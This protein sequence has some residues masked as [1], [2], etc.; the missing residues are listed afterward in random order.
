MQVLPNV[1]KVSVLREGTAMAS[2]PPREME[3]ELVSA[4]SEPG[5][6]LWVQGGAG[7]L[8]GQRGVEAEL[9]FCLGR[10]GGVMILLRWEGGVQDELERFSV[11]GETL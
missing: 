9:P 10:G 6:C 3:E 8:G 11:P 2:P 5:R 4:G 1:M 7:W